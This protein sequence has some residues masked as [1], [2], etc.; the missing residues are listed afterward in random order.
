MENQLTI[1][2]QLHFLDMSPILQ[3]DY[4]FPERKCSQFN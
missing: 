4:K 2:N 3:A 1:E